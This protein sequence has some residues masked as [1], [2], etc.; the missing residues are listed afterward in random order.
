MACDAHN[1]NTRLANSLNDIIPECN[2][3]MFKRSFIYGASIIWNTL[4]DSLKECES[5]HQ[6]KHQAKHF[7]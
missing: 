4:P 2:S 6:F 7:F 3:Q 1:I 5:I